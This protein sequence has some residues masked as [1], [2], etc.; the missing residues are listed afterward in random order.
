MKENPYLF[1]F[2][3]FMFSCIFLQ[4]ISAAQDEDK[5]RILTLRECIDLAI[6]NDPDANYA[7]DQIG[8][9]RLRTKE[10]KKSLI[11]P[12]FD[13]ETSY[14]PKLDYFGRP[15]VKE[16]IY[17]SKA[18]IE[19]P[20]YKGGELITSYRLGKSETERAQ[21]DHIQKVMEVTA[22]TIETYFRLL[23]AQE[24]LRYY[25]EL[26]GQAEKTVELLNRKFQIGAVVRVDVLEAETKLN[27]IKYDSI[28]AQGDLQ[29]AMASLNEKIGWDPAVR[30][31]VVKE[32]P[33]QPL[34]GDVD[35]L[36]AGALKDR[37]DLLYEK[38][39]L[40]FNQLS[41]KLNESK[42]LPRLS[43]VGSYSWDS[44]FYTNYAK[45]G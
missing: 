40:E 4:D 15:I 20:L 30:T 6:K 33:F 3:V 7:M 1:L 29:M 35:T 13:L 26:H 39:N 43:L 24:N 21:Y 42:E 9:G 8:I 36:I 5:E 45:A 11:L 12:R 27:E 25:Q 2:L 19:K 16:N 28:K 34:E 31:Q 14:G 32:F 41:V 37:P 22:D 23:S 18:S 17:Y 10:A 38:E 44:N